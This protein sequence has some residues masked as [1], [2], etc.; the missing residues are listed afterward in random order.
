[1]FALGSY[2]PAHPRLIALT[3][4]AE[5]LA[6]ELGA[7]DNKEPDGAW[8]APYQLARAR[9]CSPRRPPRSRRSTRCIP[10]FAIPR[11]W[12]GIA[13][14]PGATVLSAVSRS[15]PIR[16]RRST[17]PT[18]PPPPRSSSAQDR[19]R[20]R[21]QSRRGRAWSRRQDGRHSAPESGAQNPVVDLT[22]TFVARVGKLATY[23][24]K[25]QR[26]RQNVLASFSW[27]DVAKASLSSPRPERASTCQN[28]ASD[29][30]KE[31]LAGPFF[32]RPAPANVDR[33][34]TNFRGKLWLTKR[35]LGFCG[36][37]P[38]RRWSRP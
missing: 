31:D 21:G 25:A 26:S 10:I 29:L 27:I 20:V 23:H 1:M 36:K 12:S 18:R 30:Y 9:A 13:G 2:A 14:A 11:G 15:I 32:E 19:R 37:P 33:P 24:V 38:I 4:G 34:Q 16:S 22:A 35:Y 3:W 5:D 17:A 28:A 8:T 7:T 6:A